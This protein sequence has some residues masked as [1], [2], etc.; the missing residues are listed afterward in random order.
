[1]SRKS[2]MYM[3]MRGLDR[4]QE[5]KRVE[6]IN[7]HNAE[8]GYELQLEQLVRDNQNLPEQKI[9]YHGSYHDIGNTRNV[10]SRCYKIDKDGYDY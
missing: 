9:C 8:R 5:S 1:M 7:A 10:C 4:N 6:G 3:M 2:N